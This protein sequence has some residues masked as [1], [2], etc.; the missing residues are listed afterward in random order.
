MASCTILEFNASML[1]FV[2]D[3]DVQSKISL[4]LSMGDFPSFVML[5]VVAP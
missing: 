3:D 4:S 2:S 1:Y 5:I